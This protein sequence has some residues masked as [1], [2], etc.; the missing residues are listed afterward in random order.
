[1]RLE[2]NRAGKTPRIVQEPLPQDTTGQLECPI[3]QETGKQE[4][5]RFQVLPADVIFALGARQEA[6][7]LHVEEGGGND[8]KLGGAR[9]IRESLHMRNELVGD[10]GE[11]H[12][13]DIEFLAR[14]Q[15]KKQVK[16]AFEHFQGD[17]ELIDGGLF[18]EE[19]RRRRH[20]RSIP[21][22]GD[23]RRALRDGWAHSW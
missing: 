6:R 10:L 5:A 9:Q 19:I 11:R 15:L 2:R 23:G 20:G 3:L 17:L 7:G 14:D 21:V 18:F 12:L 22:R 16:R 4:V 13:G 1:M 8:Q